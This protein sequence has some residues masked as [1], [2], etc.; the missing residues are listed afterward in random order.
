MV[1]VLS[2]KQSIREPH[3]RRVG[4]EKDGGRNL[5]RRLP[6]VTADKDVRHASDPVQRLIRRLIKRL[7][8]VTPERHKINQ[9]LPPVLLPA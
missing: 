3:K 9:R 4:F 5:R 8:Q 6:A 7:T 2:E 1:S